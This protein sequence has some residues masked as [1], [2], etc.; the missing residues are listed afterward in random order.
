MAVY[1]VF[2]SILALSGRI[3]II[4]ESFEGGTDGSEADVGHVQNGAERTAR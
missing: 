1:P 2:F 4:D 3:S